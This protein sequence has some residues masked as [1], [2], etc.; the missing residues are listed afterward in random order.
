M[1]K[2]IVILILCLTSTAWGNKLS[3]AYKALS[4][5]D[6]FK[7]K[8]LFYKSISKYPSASAYGLSTIFSR[9]D[10]PFSNIDSAAKY[11]SISKNY[12][13]DSVS[14][15]GYHIN[16]KSITELS[17]KI[18]DK[19][20]EVY[21]NNRSVEQI[22]YFLV[23][24]YFATDSL[25]LISYFLRD[26]LVLAQALTSQ[27]SK[28]VKE[29]ML[30]YPQSS[31]YSQAKNNYHDFEYAEQTMAK[32]RVQYQNFI[33]KFSHNPNVD[34]AELNLFNMVKNDH[35]AD[36]LYRFIKKYSTQLTQEN[37]W[38]LLYSL[39]VNSYGKDELTAFLTKY[40]DYP[41]HQTVIKEI[42]LSQNK[43]IP[44]KYTN[45]K[46]GYIDTLG[47]WIIKPQFDDAAF[48]QD[49]LAAVCKNDSCVYI[50]KEGHKTTDAVFEETENY[51]DGIAIVKKGGYYFLM[52]RSGQIVSKGY[53]DINPSSGNL[54][55]CKSNAMYGAINA[56]GEIV[57]PFTYAKL[58]NFKNGYAYYMSTLYGL[59][60]LYNKPLI[61]QW[62]WISDVDTNSIVIV[63]KNNRFG[64]MTVSEEMVISTD[65][66]YITPCVGEIYLVVKNDFYG[67]FN[68]KEKCFVTAVEYDYNPTFETNYYTNGKY[69]KLLKMDEVALVDANGR[70]SINF[71]SYTN[72]FFAK[73]EMIRIQKNNKYGFV[74][75]KLKSITSV[76]FDKAQDFENNLA[77]VS[78]GGSSSIID[79]SGKTIYNIKN[80]DI[81]TTFNSL[82]IVKQNELVGL[83]DSSTKLLISIEFDSIEPIDSFLFACFKNGELY[84]FDTRTK[85]KVKL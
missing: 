23:H 17:V 19:G 11:I 55:V 45:D 59:V 62:D 3:D 32:T 46:F 47:N 33:Q 57:V 56:K 83:L 50:D 66:S 37:A 64:L 43:L 15:S 14:Y 27:S 28:K 61:A 5:F 36:S 18:A 84:L 52:N 81:Q 13:K 35:S 21:C 71:G 58:G 25:L 77:I 12:F 29:F 73:C 49:G 8:Q 85:N 72:I 60:D 6:Y 24:F 4:I 82:F 70:Y 42:M 67:F 80:G 79:K 7:A 31:L 75:R 20:F 16:S 40:P 9:T 69:F 48:Y 41:Y 78:K 2:I 26:S 54:F 68:V 53:E 39:S 1:R 10:N 30:D 74:D 22:H 38:K 51:K 44:L 34:D 63:K 76:E 65:Y